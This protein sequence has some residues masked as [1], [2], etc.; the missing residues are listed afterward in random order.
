[1]EAGSSSNGKMRFAPVATLALVLVLSDDAHTFSPMPFRLKR[2][3]LPT[4]LGATQFQNDG[5]F[6][7]MMAGLGGFQEGQTVVYGA[8]VT[9]DKPGNVPEEE[10]MKRRAQAALGLYNIGDEERARRDKM[11]NILGLVSLAF[12]V[13]T[14]ITSVG[15][16]G[17]VIRFG[18][19]LP[20][21]G[22]FGYKQSAA[23]GL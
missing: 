13:F 2:S 19:S 9:M 7:K 11:G 8:P 3:R 1:L 20:L 22:A 6:G 21:F 14:G 5:P 12:G 10:V 23:T 15:V 16:M 17:H 4:S 18:L